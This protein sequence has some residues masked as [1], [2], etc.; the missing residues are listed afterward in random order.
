[1]DNVGHEFVG[2]DG[3]SLDH[4]NMMGKIWKNCGYKT[5]YEGDDDFR[6]EGYKFGEPLQGCRLLDLVVC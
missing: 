5:W 1:M 4:G 6:G 2:P 3:G